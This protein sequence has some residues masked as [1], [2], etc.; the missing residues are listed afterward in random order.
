MKTQL[1]LALRNVLRHRG[2]TLVSLLMVAGAVVGLVLFIGFSDYVLSEMRRIVIDN[3]HGHLQIA[4]QAFW[5]LA[6]GNRKNQL[7]ENPD[8]LVSLVAQDKDVES[9][10]GRLS[11][12]GL[13]ST[14]EIT[15]S[16]KGLGYDPAKEVGFAKSLTIT[17][18]ENIQPNAK[19]EVLVGYGLQKKLNIAP[20]ATVTVLGYT[21]DGV[22]NAVDLTVKGIFQTSNSEIDNNVFLLPVATAQLLLDTDR[23]ELLTVRLRPE[24][25]LLTARD[26]IQTL[27]ASLMPNVRT[28]TW[29][30]LSNFFRQVESFYAVQN[31]I[32]QII[33]LSL[34]FLG[35]LNTVG[36]SVFERTGE[37]GT[38]RAMGENVP[39]IVRQF[40]LEG[41]VLGLVGALL[42]AAAGVIFSLIINACK[43]MID[44][45]GTSSPIAVA[46]NIVPAGYVEA[47][48]IVILAAVAATWFPSV[49]ASKMPIV[50]A[51]R[52]NI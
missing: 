48:L 36:M 17:K 52:K 39:S 22:V 31:R 15:I 45:P 18:G 6:P 3:E 12:Y 1:M 2:R 11:F 21:L 46:I 33:L 42:G 13:I 27:S 16:A 29:Y 44:L 28:K 23:V 5:D 20:G 4:Q 47:I 34:V 51:L 30:E 9:V 7:L 25:S 8:A 35:I 14:G 40:L 50:E 32:I 43:F 41:A 49:R 24:A 38:V 26:R 37:I 19:L 10:S